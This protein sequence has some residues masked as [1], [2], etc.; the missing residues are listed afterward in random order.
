[1]EML[2]QGFLGAV[3]NFATPELWLIMLVGAIIG[4][5]F[6]VIPG[7]SGMTALILLLPFV[8]K[9]RPEQALPLMV[10][11]LSTSFA[12]GCVSAILLNVPG[13]PAN[14]ATLLDGFP[15]TQKG[16]AG[17]ALGAAQM[18][19]GL[20]HIITAFLTLAIIPVIFPI[21]MAIRF[22]DLVFLILLGISF[23]SVLG[24]G[25][26]VKGLISGGIGLLISLVGFQPITSVPR[27]TFG[28]LYLYDGITMVPVAL[29]LFSV[30]EMIALATSGG[31]IARTK[32]AIKGIQD[33]WSGVKDTFQHWT[34]VLR[35]NIIG[36]IIGILPGIGGTPAAFITYGHAK[37]TSKHPETF[38]KGNVEGV[39]AP[40]S[41]NNAEEAGALLTTLSLGIPGNAPQALLLGA[42]II[43]GLVPGP[44]M[45]TKHLDLSLTMI[46]VMVVTGLM[47][48]AIL[49][50]LA[51]RFAGIALIPGSVLVPLILVIAFV[52]TFAYQQEA[53]DIIALLVFSMIGLVMRRFD[54][55]RPALLLAYVLGGLFEKYLFMALF[56]SGPL[57]FVRP[58]S[59]ILILAI[60]A[61]I[62][63][64]P[65]KGMFQRR[66]R[67]KTV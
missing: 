7:I 15:M 4:I 24:S 40:E 67:V 18:A 64:E 8:F 41:A 51:S 13:V 46:W 37:Q 35:S 61:V 44:E 62:C 66:R 3:H 30:P 36:Y 39:I 50:P 1:M 9:M 28:S 17:R 54:F 38:G 22:G 29:G 19:S 42:F 43:L 10:A 49:L 16:E 59:L 11:I 34:L 27:F 63:H 60:I 57:F 33:V 20:S 45:V 48:L 26:M 31:T 53:N 25:S 14:A 23:I 52:S 58:I 5:I 12:G 55:N 21:I 47:G 32:V 56:A 65:I 2:L 6:G